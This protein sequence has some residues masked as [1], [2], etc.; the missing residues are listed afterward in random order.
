MRINKFLLAIV[1][2]LFSFVL[3][4]NSVFAQEETLEATVEKILEEKQMKPMGSE[5]FQLYQKLEL[6]VTRFSKR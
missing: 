6:L 2:L 1:T 4:G 3:L 5:D